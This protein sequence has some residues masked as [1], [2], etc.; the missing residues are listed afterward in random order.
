MVRRV[1]YS[2]GCFEILLLTIITLAE[3]I[4]SILEF[5]ADN[6]AF[7]ASLSLLPLLAFVVLTPL[8]THSGN[9][10]KLSHF[11]KLLLCQVTAAVALLL[12]VLSEHFLLP[13]K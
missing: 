1:K 11:N 3:R 2:P 8:P 7:P 6:R 12:C 4:P 9:G 13:V 5:V 10:T